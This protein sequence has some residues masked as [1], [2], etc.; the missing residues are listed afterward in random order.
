MWTI[1]A[2]PTSSKILRPQQVGLEPTVLVVGNEALPLCLQSVVCRALACVLC[3]LFYKR[4]SLGPIPELLNQ[5]QTV[6]KILG[7][8]ATAWL[9]W[10]CWIVRAHSYSSFLFVI[11]LGT[12]LIHCFMAVYMPPFLTFSEIYFSFFF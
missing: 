6:N 9:L 12:L 2:K 10:A 5:N 4:S 11:I 7:S 1:L 3:G 8:R